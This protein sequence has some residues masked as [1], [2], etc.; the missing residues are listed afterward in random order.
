MESTN[1]YSNA[2]QEVGRRVGFIGDV[3]TPVRFLPCGVGSSLPFWRMKGEKMVFFCSTDPDFIVPG[4]YMIPGTSEV[5]DESDLVAI[6]LA[7]FA[8]E[9]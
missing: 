1:T 6:V 2:L 4:W 9:A 8:K 5:T 7:H 3:P